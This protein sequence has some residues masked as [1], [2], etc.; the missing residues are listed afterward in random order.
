FELLLCHEIPLQ[1][2]GCGDLI[3]IAAKSSIYST[4]PVVSSNVWCLSM[5]YWYIALRWIK[6]MTLVIPSRVFEYCK[7]VG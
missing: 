2:Q 3:L 4:K 7:L 1:G 5:A 6:S